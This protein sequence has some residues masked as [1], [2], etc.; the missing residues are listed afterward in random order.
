MF[1]DIGLI[2]TIA[3]SLSFNG[4]PHIVDQMGRAPNG[5]QWN[6]VLETG[7][8]FGPVITELFQEIF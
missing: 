5:A 6:E 3:G 7:L 2:M 8:Y 1:E 4:C